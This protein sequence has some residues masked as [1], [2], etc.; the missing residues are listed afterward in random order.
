MFRTLEP[1][2]NKLDNITLIEPINE[3]KFNLLLNSTLLRSKFNNPY[4]KFRNEREMLEKY[5]K[6]MIDDDNKK[7]MKFIEVKYLRTND[8]SF[9]RCN[10]DR[11]L[12]L[13][14]IRREIRHTL[15]SDYYV[16]IDIV[17]CHPILLYQ[18]AEQNNIKLEYLGKYIKDRDKIMKILI[19]H[20]NIT[21]DEKF[22]TTKKYETAK[23]K[24]KKLFI[25]LLYFGSFK[26]WSKE[27]ELVDVSPDDFIIGFVN[28]IKKVGKIIKNTNSKIYDEI[29]NRK[30]NQNRDLNKENLTG[31]TVSYFLQ[32]LEVRILE[33]LFLYCVDKGFI[34]NKVC[35][36]CADGLMILKEE[37]NDNLLT[38]FNV[39]IKEKL[40]FDLKFTRKELNN[41]YT[42]KELLDTQDNILEKAMLLKNF[43][44][45]QYSQVFYEDFKQNYIFDDTFGWFYYDK[46]NNIVNSGKNYPPKILNQI[47]ETLNHYVDSYKK[48]MEILLLNFKGKTEELKTEDTKAFK[49]YIKLYT[50]QKLKI[51]NS[52]FI[53]GIIK[54]LKSSYQNNDIYKKMDSDMSYI[55]FKNLVFDF[56]EMEF[57]DKRLDDYN[58]KNT[59][60]EINIVSNETIRKEIMEILKTI[61]DT[62]EKINY[63]LLRTATSLY[64]NSTE[65]L[66]IETGTGGNGKGLLS[67]LVEKALGEYFYI[68]PSNFLTTDLTKADGANSS[69]VSCKGRRYVLITEPENKTEGDSNFNIGFIK[70][71]TGSDT[72]NA[73]ELH[74]KTQLFKPTFTLF[75]QCNNKP[76][77]K[78]IDK[79]MVRR[80]KVCPFN[81]KFVEN[82]KE[83]TNERMI[84]TTLKNKFS[85]KLYYN[86]FMLLLLDTIKENFDDN[87]NYKKIM[88]PQE[89]QECTNEYIE[90]NNQILYFLEQLT[91]YAPTEEK[92]EIPTILIQDLLKH[93]KDYCNDI[94]G[95]EN[96]IKFLTPKKLIETLKFNDYVVDCKKSKRLQYV[97]NIKTKEPI[98]EG[99]KKEEKKEINDLDV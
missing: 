57:R 31:S 56:D 40:N 97:F 77:M 5:K 4:S 9:G 26:S 96:Y 54:Y 63:Y 65:S 86:E 45:Y 53:E 24:V 18:V 27:Y 75:L 81:N 20:Y 62:K 12:G 85:N 37:Y 14:S 78:K 7:E 61:F 51:G 25:T 72:I 67:S 32:E 16:D 91:D 58:I 84:N 36:L 59:G 34:K 99:E 1:Q 15:C 35:S 39:L 55:A 30:T 52:T 43:S 69:L 95:D 74:G 10:P 87:N 64:S 93:F 6:K 49:E 70:S 82:P 44:H 17:N 22:I 68:A 8:M 19:K 28:D 13:F 92:K 76:N 11:S 29:I 89:Y 94:K 33:E 38:E 79:G 71:L 48:R 88:I 90:E 83:N 66:Y 3:K 98:I 73:R 47:T 41:G 42:E 60:Y 50:A 21:D 80:L 23:D 46:F 2:N